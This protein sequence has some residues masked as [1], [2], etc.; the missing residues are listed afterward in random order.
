MP[1]SRVGWASVT[2]DPETGNIYANGVQGLVYCL[3]PEGKLLWSKSTTELYGRVTGYGGRTYTPIIDEDRVIVAFNNSGFG[4]HGVGAHRF[5]AL[6]KRTGDIVWWG[7]PGGRPEDPTYSDPVV[8]V[9]NGERLIIAGN[10]DGY[11]YAIKARTGEKVWGFDVSQRGLNSAPVVDGYRVYITHSE[12]NIDTSSQMGRVLC[13]DGRGHGDITKTNELWRADGVDDGY[14]TPLLH[15]KRLYTMNNSGVLFCF[16]SESGKKFWEFVAGREGKGSPVWADGKIY[17]TLANGQFKIL[18]D[19]G[20]SC[21]ILDSF[22]FNSGPEKGIEIFASPAVSDG[23]IAFC[24]TTEMVCFG[25]Q[26][27][28]PQPVPAEALPDEAAVQKDPATL[29][30]QPAEVLLRPGETVKFRVIAYDKHGRRIGPI[31]STCYFPLKLGTLDTK[32]QFTAGKHGGIGEVRAEVGK[33]TGTAR[34]RIVPELP[35]SEDFESYKD[36]DVVGWWIGVSKA[37]YT[38]TT[39]D[40]SKVLKKLQTLKGP[41]FDRSHAYI[42]PP[43]PAGY[44]VEGDGMGVAFS[45]TRPSAAAATRAWSTIATC[46]SFGGGK[47][48]RVVSWIPGPRFEKK[49]DFPWEPG[50]WYRVKLKVDVVGNEGKIY[51]KVWP[52]SEAEPKE[53]TIEATDPQ[54]NL[55][56]LGGSLFQQHHGARVFRQHQSLPLKSTIMKTLAFPTLAVLMLTASPAF[57]ADWPM[58]GGTPQRNMINTVEKNIPDN[59]DV[60]TGKNIKWVAQLGSQSFGSPVIAG[61]KVFVGTNNQA[62][63]QPAIKGD[64]GI[65]MCF[66]ESDGKFLWQNVHDKLAAGRVNDWPLQG[67][68]STPCVEGNRVYYVSNRCEL[69]CTDVNGAGDGSTN[70]KILW[71]LD[72]IKDLGVF[73][74][75]M[76]ASSPNMDGNL[77]YVVTGNGVDEGHIV[78][79][80]P[81]PPASSP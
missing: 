13:I 27:A 50:T 55:R 79:P 30:I 60:T 31:D 45:E 29:L 42:T 48:A 39:L 14:A 73:P 20:D 61:G 57:T 7:S 56:R 11:L 4:P 9:I 15:N 74:H 58:W 28:K 3:S 26:D 59:W 38:I 10:A 34:V 17:V 78:V 75:N 41:V 62:E 18:E 43:I 77:V 66:R 44:T 24:T 5:L 67:I 64:K 76:S 81:T 35:I 1:D 2:V 51:A 32:G 25:K 8:A 19:K 72:M 65:F 23:R 47:K 80:A 36:G 70:G 49:I 52:R 69:V 6:N 46:S 16:D 68:C 54:P 21:Q 63:R 53:W 33:I 71:K 40:G 22:N 37:K 12:E